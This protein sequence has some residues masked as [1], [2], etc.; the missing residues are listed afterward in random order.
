MEK[1][2]RV[3]RDPDI[4]LGPEINFGDNNNFGHEVKFC[5]CDAYAAAVNATPFEEDP[6]LDLPSWVADRLLSD[7]GQ[8]RPAPGGRWLMPHP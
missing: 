5:P 3:K 7:S 4:N 1:V 8:V 2:L 6:I